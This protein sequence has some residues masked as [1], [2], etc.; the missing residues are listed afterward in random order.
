VSGE[1]WL[2]PGPPADTIIYRCSGLI[3]KMACFYFIYL[4]GRAVLGLT[5]ARQALYHSSH[6]ASPLCVHVR[7]LSVFEIGSRTICSVLALNLDPPDLC[8]HISDY[9]CEPPAKWHSFSYDLHTSA[10]IVCAICRCSAVP[11]HVGVSVHTQ[12]NVFWMFSVHTWLAEGTYAV[13]GWLCLNAAYLVF[14]K[15]QF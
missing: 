3:H 4:F 10:C 11:C 6:S 12:H 2:V 8:S 7:V 9:R 1:G 15:I 14:V 13:R 5:L